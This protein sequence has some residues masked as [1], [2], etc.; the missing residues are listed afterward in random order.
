VR[1]GERRGEFFF[2]FSFFLFCIFCVWA[3]CSLSLSL[4]L[5]LFFS[6][7]KSLSLLFRYFFFHFC[8]ALLER[9]EEKERTEEGINRSL[10]H[11]RT[12][13]RT[14]ARAHSL[15][16]FH[17][18]V[19]IYIYIY[20]LKRSS[21]GRS[22]FGFGKKKERFQREKKVINESTS[23]IRVCKRQDILLL[24]LSFLRLR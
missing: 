9:E 22:K 16:V 5:S 13:A 8:C 21:L 11:T 12:H 24:L 4:S 1:P 3:L 18:R 20:S 2:F 17:S 10:S 15:S 6:R 19:L 14:H 7:T 23:N